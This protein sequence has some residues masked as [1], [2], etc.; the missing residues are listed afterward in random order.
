MYSVHDRDAYRSV[1]VNSSADS[2]LNSSWSLSGGAL[3][4][5]S[6]S[7]DRPV[8][9]NPWTGLVGYVPDAPTSVSRFDANG[10][11]GVFASGDALYAVDLTPVTSS[12]LAVPPDSV[13]PSVTMGGKTSSATRAYTVSFK[14]TDADAVPDDQFKASGVVRT[15]ARHRT[16]LRGEE[17]FGMEPARRR[18]EHA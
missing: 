11:L 17:R 5:V 1:V 7:S 18:R 6:R 2:I 9:M 16:R 13:A 3:I 15:E 10:S 14:A 8:A 4:G 12:I